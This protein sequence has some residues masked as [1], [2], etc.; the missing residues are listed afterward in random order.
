MPGQELAAAGKELAAKKLTEKELG[1]GEEAWRRPRS[2]AATKE[3]AAKELS[4]RELG[5]RDLSGGTAAWRRGIIIE[6][7]EVEAR[8]DLCHSVRRQRRAGGTAR[9]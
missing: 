7:A 2:S 6:R 5:G 3:L 8:G 9:W 1:G 4:G